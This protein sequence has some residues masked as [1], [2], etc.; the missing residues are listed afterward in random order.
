MTEER[1]PLSPHVSVSLSLVVHLI[2]AV[3]LLA[4][5]PSGSYLV[6][7]CEPQV[8]RHFLLTLLFNN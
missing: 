8:T 2:S 3:S 1:G 4:S 5:L 7:H 6:S